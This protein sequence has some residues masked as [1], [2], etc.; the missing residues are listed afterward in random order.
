MISSKI[1][2]PDKKLA[3][4]ALLLLFLYMTIPAYGQQARA[5]VS[6]QQ[7]RSR[8]S[9]RVDLS[10][11]LDLQSDKKALQDFV[12][13]LNDPTKRISN[14][15]IKT[16]ENLYHRSN[17]WS[18]LDPNTA[19][20]HIEVAEAFERAYLYSKRPDYLDISK[21]AYKRT[22]ESTSG[23]TKLI[24]ST[25]L[26]AQL[27]RQ[28]APDEAAM[29]MR[30][31]ENTLRDPSLD[32]V[33]KSQGFYNFGSAMMQLKEYKYAYDLLKAAVDADPTS[34]MAA[35]AA[36]EAAL[37][38][39]H[40]TTGIPQIF[41]LTNKQLEG[42]NLKGIKDNLKKAMEVEHWKG[43]RLYPLLIEQM[44]RY[45]VA[46]DVKAE[47]FE[48]EWW[49]FLE[50]ILAQARLDSGSKT[51]ILD[52]NDIYSGNLKKPNVIPEA[53]KGMYFAWQKAKNDGRFKS[54]LEALSIFL[55]MRGDYYYRQRDEDS[56][57]NS[58]K[59]YSHAWALN[60]E[61]V[62]AGLYLANVL[63]LDIKEGDKKLDQKYHIF[64][65]FIYQL[66]VAKNAQ[67]QKYFSNR[68]T[69]W[70][71]ILKCHIVLATIFEQQQ[72]WGPGGNPRTAIF[73]WD[74]AQKA[75]D[76]LDASAAGTQRQFGPVIDRGLRQ[77]R[78]QWRKI[79]R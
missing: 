3:N 9:E 23:R 15:N 51:M 47:V 6:D 26:C 14:S 78:A 49:P 39:D 38:A 37:N 61:N 63:L 25:K 69:D 42:F 41:E 33:T 71:R 58:L 60:V 11:R 53:V 55:Q 7:N 48:R 46:S 35:R 31:V 24:A 20:V 4:L 28:N 17:N 68:V 5:R 79:N 77:A 44:L 13:Q 12:T 18:R 29:V 30:N 36:G 45:F 59:C 52:I 40:E 74:L 65:S 57:E 22:I 1:F 50:N 10:N 73:Q 54:G 27:L 75:L 64:D 21:S 34:R 72:A 56:L 67:Y 43:H 8:V 2:L 32:R 76:K 62:E 16:I 70:E 19:T 66:F